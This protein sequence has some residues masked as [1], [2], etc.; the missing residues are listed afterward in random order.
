MAMLKIV[1]V[2]LVYLGVSVGVALAQDCTGVNPKASTPLAAFNLPASHSCTQRM[3]NGFSIP[4]LSCTPGAINK[5]VTLA[6]LKRPGFKTDCI[7]DKA[8]TAHA[9]AG[10]YD[11]Y[12]IQHPVNNKGSHQTCELD[13]LISLELGGAD[14][15]DNIWPQCGATTCGKMES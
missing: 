14:T 2:S 1:C 8:S 12:D 10:T 9:K 11:W 6:V 15:L 3:K 5:T 4:D 13:H 7:R